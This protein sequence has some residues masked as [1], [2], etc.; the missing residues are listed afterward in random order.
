[1]PLVIQVYIKE[2]QEAKYPVYR[3][4][5]IGRKRGHIR[6]EDSKVSSTHAR[7]DEDEFGQ[8][9]LV[10]LNSSNG[11]VVKGEK[12]SRVVLTH[13]IIIS[14]GRAELHV[15]YEDEPSQGPLSDLGT[16]L[17]TEPRFKITSSPA[18]KDLDVKR[19]Q[20]LSLWL[21]KLTLSTRDKVRPVQPFRPPL[22]LEVVTGI[23]V[24]DIWT[25]GYGPRQAG[26]H[27]V[28]LCLHEPKAPDLC[29]TLSP[30]TKDGILFE[31]AYPDQVLLNGAS[32]RSEEL[33]GTE[34]DLI[35]IFDTTIRISRVCDSN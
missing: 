35:A 23:Q 6:I 8:L 15:V 27:S 34:S 19:R 14:L 10:D 1:M 31:T 12:V 22:R 4:L 20:D 16:G 21:Q 3:G 7:V 9:V 13:G 28:D 29:F 2:K 24:G 18:E 33:M 5:L 17:I 32:K 25:L 30:T 11:L 26:P